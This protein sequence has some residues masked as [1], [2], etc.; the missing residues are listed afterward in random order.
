[1]KSKMIMSRM[2]VLSERE[3]TNMTDIDV[4]VD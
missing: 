2:V 1:M 4:T 3:K